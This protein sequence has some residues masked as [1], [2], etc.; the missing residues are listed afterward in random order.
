MGKRIEVSGGIASGKTT[1]VSGLCSDGSFAVFERFRDTQFYRAFYEDPITYAFE[2]EI[3]F[4]LQHYHML[5]RERARE[6]VIS[7][8]SLWLDRAYANTNLSGNKHRAFLAVWNEILSDIGHPAL[9]VHLKCKPDVLMNRIARRRRPEEAGISI[10]YISKLNLQINSEVTRLSEITP[11]LEIS[12]D[13]VDFSETA[14]GARRTF[15][16]INTVVDEILISGIPAV[17]RYPASK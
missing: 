16:R 12:S 8:Y 2:T 7:D 14:E 5:K 11:V 17:T 13:E 3:D 6:K 9:V 1:F 4:L 15:A 10:D